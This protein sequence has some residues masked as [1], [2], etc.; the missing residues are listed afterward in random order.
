MFSF[1]SLQIKFIL[2]SSANKTEAAVTVALKFFFD[3]IENAPEPQLSSINVLR[4]GEQGTVACRVRHACF[5]APPTLTL[6][7]IPGTDQTMDT[8]VSEGI[9]ERTVQ[10]IWTI[11]EK[12]QHV[13]C[14]VRYP[15]G[16]TVKKEIPLHV[17]CEY[18]VI[19]LI[20]TIYMY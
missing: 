17:E 18:N 2:F 3:F 9:W 12:D 14:A 6:T 11:E 1:H 10:R 7:G 20:C 4:V 15:G 8:R 13:S 5:S 16:Q 19:Y